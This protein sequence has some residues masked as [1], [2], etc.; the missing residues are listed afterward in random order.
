MLGRDLS[1]LKHKRH[2]AKSRNTTANSIRQG[3]YLVCQEC[4]TE[5][6]A[7]FCGKARSI[8][9]T[10]RERTAVQYGCKCLVVIGDVVDK[11]GNKNTDSWTGMADF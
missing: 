4:L 1:C 5:G 7:Q 11:E 3:H 6:I 2:E 8:V 10:W 9:V